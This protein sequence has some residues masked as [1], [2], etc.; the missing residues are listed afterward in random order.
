MIIKQKDL[1]KTTKLLWSSA[2]AIGLGF[3]ILAAL[4]LFSF[5]LNAI[6]EGYFSQPGSLKG[7]L[8]IIPILIGP[9]LLVIFAMF[10]ERVGGFLLII[11]SLAGIIMF[12]I[13]SPGGKWV[14]FLLGGPFLISGVLFLLSYYSHKKR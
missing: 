9:S 8:R 10:K 2:V 12:Q 5:V 6:F 7:L 13:G 3:V 4:F 14:G 1:S 11:V